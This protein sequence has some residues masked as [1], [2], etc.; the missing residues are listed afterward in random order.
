MRLVWALV[1]KWPVGI[2]LLFFFLVRGAASWREASLAAGLA[3]YAGFYFGLGERV[4]ALLGWARPAGERLRTSLARVAERAG[5]SVPCAREL[6][7]PL[8]NAFLVP[9]SRS[10][11]VTRRALEILTE[12]ELEAVLAHELG[13][14]RERR[15]LVVAMLPSHAAFVGILLACTLL[16]GLALWVTL[17]LLTVV[18]LLTRILLPRFM[19]AAEERADAFARRHADPTAFARAL[20]CLYRANLIPP[21][22]GSGA[23]HPD[24]ARRIEAAGASVPSDLGAAPPRRA[25]VF[26]LVLVLAFACAF[27]LRDLV[28]VKE[29]LPFPRLTLALR[30]PEPFS[31]AALAQAEERAG[32]DEA[33]RRLYGGGSALEPANPWWPMEEARLLARLGRCDEARARF[34]EAERLC[35]AS[36]EFDCEGWLAQGAVHLAGCP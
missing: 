11:C 13:H 23:L 15:R 32:R 1:A 3:L 29:D 16:Q 25:G 6:D 21:R 5:M 20:D 26:V 34:A 10:L 18:A 9:V 4:L 36:G 2:A 31:I 35:Q 24:F 19:R 30:G 22:R 14:L 27:G 28:L 33:A 8:P 17:A 12:D 7:H